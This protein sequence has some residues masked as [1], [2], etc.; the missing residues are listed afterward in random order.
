MNLTRPVALRSSSRREILADPAAAELLPP[1][2][3]VA[4]VVAC[5][6]ENRQ[7]RQRLRAR[8]RELA[9]MR[10][11]MA[12][13]VSDD[14]EIRGRLRTLEEV[15]AALHGNIEDLRLQRDQLLAGH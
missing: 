3:L 13:H 15:V 1:A 14:A 7:L 6:H 9:E 5:E 10:S 4:A 12:A 11:A 2:E 8:K